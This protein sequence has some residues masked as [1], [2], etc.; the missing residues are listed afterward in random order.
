MQASRYQETPY[1]YTIIAVYLLASLVNQIPAN[2]FSAM[3]SKVE[4]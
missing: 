4:N 1:R 3:T 2:T